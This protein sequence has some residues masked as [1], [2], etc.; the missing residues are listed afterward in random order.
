MR[1][2]PL[3]ALRAPI[4]AEAL[5]FKSESYPSEK[6]NGELF[7]VEANIFSDLL[8]LPRTG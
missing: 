5:S 4:H 6:S 3:L 1:E 2:I 7:T 8:G